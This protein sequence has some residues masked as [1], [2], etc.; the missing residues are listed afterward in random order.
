MAYT[1]KFTD[2]RKTP[3][4]LDESQTDNSTDITLFGRKRLAYGQELQ[5]NLLHIL[6]NFSCPEDPYNPGN[7]DQS[8]SYDGIFQDAIEGQFWYN[9]TKDVLCYYD[10][11]FWIPLARQDGVAANWGL[12]SDGSFLPKPISEIS[13]KIFDY[14]EC[15]WIVSPFSFPEKID[16]MECSASNDG[17]V[18]SKYRLK[19]MNT[20]NSGLANYLIVGITGNV[21]QPQP[22]LNPSPTPTVSPTPSPG[23]S[24][25]PTPTVTPSVTRTPSPTPTNTPQPSV[26]MTPSVTV[27]PSVSRT[28][29]R[30][31]QPSQTPQ[32]S[33]SLLRLT[34]PSTTYHATCTAAPSTYCTPS[35]STT[36]TA[37][38][39]LGP[40]TFSYELMSGDNLNTFG[41]FN[42]AQ[43]NPTLSISWIGPNAQVGTSYTSVF[44]FKVTDS[45]G[46]F[47]YTDNVTVT[48]SYLS[49]V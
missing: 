38:G 1:I 16:Y 47:A 24:H 13:G 19:G 20:L 29:T 10:G 44:R 33:V 45:R 39:G 25:T 41:S 7:P 36:L 40:Y 6:E 43:S 15:V 5:E 26:T 32:P 2:K 9:S 30:T 18:T 4:V 31:P 21:N 48:Y 42:T 46:A 3:I 27:T 12:I 17:L 49:N 22:T 8:K 14:S 37:T 28:P 35:T 11:Q 34:I 23:S